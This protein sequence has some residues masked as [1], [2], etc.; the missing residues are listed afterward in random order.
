MTNLIGKFVSNND[1]RKTIE[2]V[3]VHVIRGGD[4]FTHDQM[5][6]W[7]QIDTDHKS[8]R[9][10]RGPAKVDRVVLDRNNGGYWI[11]PLHLFVR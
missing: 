9:S 4:Q 1:F 8:Y 2:G 5:L 6:Q 10:V 11:A 3:I 7:A